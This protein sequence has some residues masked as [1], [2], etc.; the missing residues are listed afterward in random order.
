MPISTT[1]HLLP[2][3]IVSLSPLMVYTRT[4]YHAPT[5]NCLI[6]TLHLL[7]PFILFQNLFSFL[8]WMHP[9]NTDGSPFTLDG[10]HSP[11]AA[12]FHPWLSHQA[13]HICLLRLLLTIDTCL[14]HLIPACHT[15]Y[16]PPTTDCL[17]VIDCPLAVTFKSSLVIPASGK[18][19][20]DYS[21]VIVIKLW[22]SD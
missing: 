22:Q 7:L 2:Q 17:L 18:I 8:P 14:P 1:K 12:S 5:I 13:L 19:A 3:L 21:P 11:F 9:S 16:S 4:W 6:P 15:S 20:S 10:L